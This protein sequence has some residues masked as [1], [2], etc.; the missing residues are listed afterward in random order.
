MVRLRGNANG[1][2]NCGLPDPASDALLFSAGHVVLWLS[3]D[4]SLVDA[5]WALFVSVV[6]SV[7]PTKQPFVGFFVLV[8]RLLYVLP[9]FCF[10]ILWGH[11][12]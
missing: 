2:E 10:G 7:V 11:D 9:P 12:G 8:W 6:A 3:L 4:I 1:E 5:V